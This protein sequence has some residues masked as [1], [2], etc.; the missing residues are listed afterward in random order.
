MKTT[1]KAFI[2]VLMPAY[3]V[4]KYIRAS[5]D[6]VLNQT[7]QDFELLIIDD[8]SSDNTLA[9]IKS[10]TD[11][12]IKV[13]EN[14]INK[15]LIYTLNRGLQHINTPYI[16]RTDADDISTPDRLQKQIEL[17][18]R[19]PNIGFCGTWL[20]SFKL[21]INEQNISYYTPTKHEEISIHLFFCRS[22]GGPPLIRKSILNKYNIQYDA[23]EVTS[24]DYD[25][26][27]K[28]SKV[29]QMVNIPEVLYHYRKHNDSIC[30]KNKNI[31]KQAYKRIVKREVSLFYPNISQ[32]EI[33]LHTKIVFEED[34]LGVEE[35][36]KAISH[37]EK[38]Y[39]INQKN[40]IFGQ[41]YFKQFLEKWVLK[42]CMKNTN[43]GLRIFV[44]YQKSKLKLKIGLHNTF[45]F[46]LDC[47]LKQKSAYLN[48]NS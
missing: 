41:S 45:R 16:S 34:I 6:S 39:E 20:N 44:L 47:L 28:I 38:L 7:F 12:R 48:E 30:A 11:K 10:Y 22:W 4:E 40:N 17:M 18:E 3:N 31:Q 24:E 13:L 27:L 43:Q 5:I 8:G 23:R 36:K 15:G 21:S 19:N 26:Y 1:N 42:I 9:I 25:L 29:S 35:V 46:F 33:G 2:T 37:L 32:N 14:T